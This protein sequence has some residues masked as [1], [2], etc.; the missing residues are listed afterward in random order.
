MSQE[1]RARADVLLADRFHTAHR[2]SGVFLF[3][4]ELGS[5]PSLNRWRCHSNRGLAEFSGFQKS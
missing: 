2:E 4:N 1:V 5:L 3:L